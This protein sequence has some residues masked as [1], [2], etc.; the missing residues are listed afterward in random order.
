MKLECFHIVWHVLAAAYRELL[1]LF[2]CVPD[3]AGLCLEY[4]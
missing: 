2:N 3:M 4:E 1:Q